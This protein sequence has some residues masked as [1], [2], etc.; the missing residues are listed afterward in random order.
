MPDPA[1]LQDGDTLF[2]GVNNRLHPRQLDAGLVSDALNRMFDRG[3]AR[4]RWSVLQPAWGGLPNVVRVQLTGTAGT[5]RVSMTPLIVSDVPMASI[6]SPSL[7][8]GNLL[9]DYVEGVT[10]DSEDITVDSEDITV[11]AGAYYDLHRPLVSSISLATAYVEAGFPT[12]FPGPIV[13]MGPFSDP[14]FGRLLLLVAVDAKRGDGG[15]GR[16]YALQAGPT[17]IEIPMNGH[18]F[19]GTVRFIQAFN[20]VVMLRHGQALFTF[21]GDAMN[22]SHQITLRVPVPFPTGTRVEWQALDGSTDP[23]RVKSNTHYYARV[24]S[25]K[26]TLHPTRADAVD[27][28]NT[29]TLSTMAA[30]QRY[31]LRRADEADAIDNP[32]R[33]NGLP[34]IMQ[35]TA[36]TREAVAAGFDSVPTQLFI[37]AADANLDTLTVPIHRL[38]D[39]DSVTIRDIRGV[40]GVSNTTYWVSV[41][42]PST[43][44]LHTTQL[45]AL[46]H[47]DHVDITAVDDPAGTISKTAAA[48]AP[49]PPGREGCYF[50]NRL[51][52]LYGRDFLA[53]SDVLDPLH[54]MPFASEFRLNAGTDDRTIALVPFNDTSIIVFKER[55][56]LAIEN[57][58]GD[59]SQ[60]RL[61]EITR[62]YGCVAPLSIVSAGTDLLFL[63]QRGVCSLNQTAYG[64]TQSVL[65]PLSDPIQGYIERIVWTRVNEACAAYF[66]NCYLLSVPCKD[67]DSRTLVYSFVTRSWQGRWEGATLKPSAYAQMV[68]GGEPALVFADQV[69]NRVHMFGRGKWDQS[70]DGT[71]TPIDTLIRTRGYTLGFMAHKQYNRADVVLSTWLPSYS[72][73]TVLDGVNETAQLLNG[74]TRDRTRYLS[75]G[76]KRYSVDNR[77]Y[78]FFTPFR[79]DYSAPVGFQV[80]TQATETD[81]H[82][83]GV[84]PGLLQAMVHKVSLQR[85][86]G[87]TIQLEIES[88]SGEVVVQ[89]IVIEGADWSSS[90]GRREN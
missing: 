72:V 61:T 5:S 85:R 78:D 12:A 66:E 32:D 19:E 38:I 24:A 75:Y 90:S 2:T 13:G 11:D 70:C 1:L 30:T 54:Y 7:G 18:D 4:N 9:L 8:G 69:A 59:L 65:M 39:G 34:L 44:R 41:V 83:R 89:S 6:G 35:P 26:V 73:R 31:C 52:L 14:E 43:I 21:N 58:Y 87:D 81:P 80:M 45:L 53:V 68:W 50:Q 48:G 88:E 62:E 49:I 51:L 60:V 29:I 20:G 77:Y 63:S 40:S 27:G 10:V 46:A 82:R 56:I 57:I 22:A 71:Q 25:G 64:L 86:H 3:V 23:G 17:A 28:T 33:N 79:A 42:A 74:Q 36:E 15:Q 84:S 55:S 47:S 37:T 76:R 67:I 16:V